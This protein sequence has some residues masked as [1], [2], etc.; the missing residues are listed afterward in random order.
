[1]ASHFVQRIVYPL[2]QLISGRRILSRVIEFEQNQWLPPIEI[3]ALQE[4]RLQNLLLHAYQQVPF[5]RTR[6]E[7]VGFQPE[8]TRSLYIL[9]T[10]PFLTKDDILTHRDELIASNYSLRS[11]KLNASGGSSGH[12]LSFYNDRA[13]LD[14]RSAVTIRGDRWA[15]LEY[16]TPH[17][18]LWGAPLDIKIQ[19]RLWNRLNNYLLNRMWLDCFR[20]SES[21]M[22]EYAK[23]LQR[24]HPQVLLGYATALATFARYLQAN[25]IRDIRPK[26]IISSAETLLD[27]QREI[28]ETV[29]GCKVFNRYG[30]REAGPLAC[31]CDRGKLHQ[32]ADYVVIEVL[33]DDQPASPG[34]IGEIVITPLFSYGMPLIRYRIGD[35]GIAAE[36]KPCACRRGLPIIDR[37]VGRSSDMMVNFSGELFHGEFFT[38]LF[39]NLPGIRQFQVIQPDRQ[40][41]Q[42]KLVAGPEF[43]FQNT[44][45][46][47]AKIKA[48]VGPMIISWERV[49]E[50]P[51]LHSGKRAFTISQVN[52]SETL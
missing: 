36:P 44:Q 23:R 33:K 12:I 6:M 32:N 10:L 43:D 41:L 28:I 26:G 14:A 22:S 3:N 11:L 9:R 49:D 27:E 13:S 40:H 31:E 5:Y 39:Y 21:L 17:A 4:L 25:H 24:F 19:Q 16:G 2:Y 7:S 35:L 15:G 46:L 51:L 52:L 48:F 1:M 38:H 29:F 45:I 18:R 8:S 42:F 37:I 20:L 50:I 30:C 34:E 47:E